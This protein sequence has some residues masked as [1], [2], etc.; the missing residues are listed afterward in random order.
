MA[1]VREIM[2]REKDLNDLQPVAGSGK[3][4][5]PDTEDISPYVSF[6][7][8]ETKETNPENPVTSLA[9]NADALHELNQASLNE[10]FDYFSE[11]PLDFLP[12]LLART[13]LK[14]YLSLKDAADNGRIK[15]GTEVII[16]DGKPYELES[17]KITGADGRKYTIS[18]H[19]PLL[20]EYAEK[21][22]NPDEEM[23]Y[24]D[25]VFGEEVEITSEDIAPLDVTEEEVDTILYQMSKLALNHTM[26]SYKEHCLSK[27][28][29]GGTPGAT[30]SNFSTALT[31]FQ[32]M[33]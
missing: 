27:L 31:V 21:I 9:N 12:P 14:G 22:I 11:N 8:F 18:G 3:Y 1:S 29:E 13:L 2:P 25:D 6:Q 28:N 7:G 20:D 4:A 26:N 24:W 30:L 16:K 5:V 32:I 33:K 15:A 17:I 19:T 23:T 10:K